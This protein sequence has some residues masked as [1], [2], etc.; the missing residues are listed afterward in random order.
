MRLDKQHPTPVYRQ[1]KD[2]LRNQIEQGIYRSHQKLPSERNLCQHY[3]LSRMTARRAL[4]ELIDEGLAYTRVGKGTFV[5]NKFNNSVTGFVDNSNQSYGLNL[6]NSITSRYQQGLVS[7]LSSFNSVEAEKIISD[8][9]ASSSLEFVAMTL[10]PRVIRQL[11]QQWHQGE[12][13]LLAQNYAITTL[14]SYLIAMFNSAVTSESGPKILLSCAP[15]DQHEIGL[16]LLALSLRRRGFRVIYLGSNITSSDFH[17]VIDTARPGLICFSAET[18]ES[19]K[20]LANL[21][22]QCLTQ[23][24]LQMNI[25]ENEL[26]TGPILTFGGGAFIQN[27]ALIPKMQGLYLGDSIEVAVAKIEELF[28]Q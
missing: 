11:E 20:A 19:G 18:M 4:Q 7:H 5:S 13:S 2:L 6:S 12:V 23:L 9:L 17:Q 26:D 1:L 21:S 24:Q 25:D 14:R 10:F 3:K 27:P 15:H 22:L 16:L 28:S 8:A